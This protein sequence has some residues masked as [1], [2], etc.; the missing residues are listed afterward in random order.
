MVNKYYQKTNKSFENKHVKDIK[1]FLKKKKKKRPKKG[2]DKYQI[3]SEGEKE[4]KHQSHP[5]RN[6]NFSKEE[7]Q[8]KVE[9]MRNYYLAIQK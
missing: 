8:K 9:Y 3:L 4:K 2:R 7:K 5:D 6:K 1:N